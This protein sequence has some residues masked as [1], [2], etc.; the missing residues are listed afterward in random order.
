[1]AKQLSGASWVA[2]FPDAGTTSSLDASFRPGCQSFIA[3]LQSAGAIATINS[4]RR[5]AERAYLMHFSWRIHKRT[6]NPENVPP[7][8]GVDIEWVHRKPDGSIDLAKSRSAATAMVNRYDIAFQPAL[9]S[10][11]VMGKAIDMTVSWSGTLNVARKE[12]TKVAIAAPRNGSNLTLR[13][14]GKSYGVIKH[15]TDPPHWSVDGR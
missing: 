2:K 1:M 14:V 11:H 7:K 12:G 3:A 8:A 10:H 6:L 9:N 15:P 4:T 13:R 5:P